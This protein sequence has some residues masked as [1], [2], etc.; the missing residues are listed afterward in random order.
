MRVDFGAG[1]VCFD[2]NGFNYEEIY[3][4]DDLKEGCWYPTIDIGTG[5]D[6]ATVVIPPYK[7]IDQL[8]WVE[9]KSVLSKGSLICLIKLQI[10]QNLNEKT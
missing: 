8:A 7:K 4:S 6:S 3:Q 2:L 1:T 5:D 10:I 9:A